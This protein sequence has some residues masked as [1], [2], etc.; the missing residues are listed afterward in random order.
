M[1]GF[2]EVF[3]KIAERSRANNSPEEGDYKND[4]GFWVCGKCHSPREAIKSMDRASDGHRVWV[5]CQ[6]R[7][8]EWKN[9]E[10]QREAMREEKIKQWRAEEAVRSVERVKSVSLMDAKLRGATFQN[11]QATQDNSRNLNICKRYADRFEVM[12]SKSQGLLFYGDVGTGKSYAAA[13]IANEL[14]NRGVP[15]VITSL[16]KMIDSLRG[17][18]T[19][20]DQVMNRLRKARLLILDEV[21]AERT[22]EFVLEKMYQIIDARYNSNLP[23]IVTTNIELPQMTNEKNIE[24][25]RIYSRIM[26][27]CYPMQWYGESWR[28]KEARQRYAEMES[29]LGVE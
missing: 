17:F 16:V 19:D 29:L 22:T 12:E 13:C 3:A 4:E 11:A 28:T 5:Q 24:L 23:M 1:Q 9:Q 25:R 26:E 27:K 7:E 21:G 14:L 10:A 15:V 2:E 6:C 18:E 20:V 8:Q